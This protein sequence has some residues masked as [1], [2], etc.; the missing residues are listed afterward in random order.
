VTDHYVKYGFKEGRLTNSDWSQ[1]ELD[2]WVDAD[3]FVSNGDVQT[4]FLG[5]QSEG[6]VAFGKIGFAHWINFGRY[7]ARDDGQPT[8]MQGSGTCLYTNLFSESPECKQYSGSAW[9]PTSAAAACVAGGTGASPGTWSASSECMLDSMLGSCSASDPEGLD[10]VL[11][12]GGS[13]PGGCATSES[14]CTGFLAGIFT[15][16][17]LCG[18]SDVPATSASACRYDNLFSGSPECKQYSG[19]GWTD[20]SA[21]ADCAAGA[22]AAPPGAWT[23]NSQCAVEPTLG[24]CSVLPADGLDY[25]IEIGG[26]E[27]RDCTTSAHACTAFVG[28][29]FIA[30]SHC[31][32]YSQ[33]PMSTDPT[34]STIFKWPTQT[35]VSALE[36][37]PEGATDGEVCTWN[38]ISAS[39]EEGRRYVDYG[40]CDVVYSNRPY[41]PLGAWEEPPLED[42]R[43][44][45]ATW[46]AES[47]WVASQV[48]SSACV[49]CHSDA[50]PSGA[51]RW[52]VDSG[53]LWVETMSDEALALFSGHTD[54]S[55]L[56]AFDPA[57]NNG[58]DRVNS[59]M[60]TTDVPRMLAFFQ[61]ELERR[62]VTDTF[63][64][65]L[66]DVGG[67]LLVQRDFVPGVCGEG[68][69]MDAAGDLVWT[70]AEARYL[71]V[72]SAESANP[73]LPPNFDL[74]EG[75]LW[76]ADVLHDVDPFASGVAYGM[77]PM[78][79]LQRFPE[80]GAP[81]ALVSGQEYYLYVLQDVAIPLARCL[82]EAP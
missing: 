35:C 42:P 7:E 33:P 43:Y 78:G 80:S 13:D 68:E 11:E 17:A 4:Y 56:G 6:W 69:G 12:I 29:T 31:E 23:A 63:L 18:G 59:A 2:A 51:S 50:A 24:S 10:Y 47:D 65:G 82:F 26:S 67:P 34:E 45:D 58:F 72:L 55:V 28:G 62:G 41:Y 32:G 76:R 77:L 57:D 30:S 40:S 75:I 66:L 52:S 49:C 3:Y 19:S 21:E 48:R 39:T 70:G 5:A 27:Q 81:Q 74:P 73:G 1:A 14:A 64:Q 8:S 79:A 38:L 71:Y 54:S 37:E 25:V 22:T 61:G 44:D 60:P 20:T 53:P 16:S 36:G 46:L 9:T 15:P